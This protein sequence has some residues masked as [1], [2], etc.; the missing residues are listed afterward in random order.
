V[1]QYQTGTVQVTNGN[2]AVVGTGTVWQGVVH[3]GD[4][5]TILG[6]NVWYEVAADAPSNTSL[7][8][9][10]NYG[11]TSGSG[12]AYV[13]TNSFTPNM[14]IP[15]IEQGDVETA[16]LFKRA[17]L[18]CESFMSGRLQKSVAGNQ[19]VTL[20]AA[21]CRNRKLQF[22]GVITGNLAVIVP[23]KERG[24][25]VF[26]NTTG[27]FTLTVKTAAGTGIVIGT[28]KHAQIACDTVNVIR[29]Q[30]DV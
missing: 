29:E 27:A 14:G 11:G 19:N 7:A 13:I 3:A 1:S 30:A 10:A 23:T 17:M 28:G 26:N 2:T 21:E 25:M 24:W 8:L 20:T 15:Y 16:S 6:S 22:N 18:Y 5:F 4:I 9:S 12:N